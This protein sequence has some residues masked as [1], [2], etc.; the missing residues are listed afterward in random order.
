MKVVPLKAQDEELQEALKLDKLDA[1][2]RASLRVMRPSTPKHMVED[3]IKPGMAKLKSK[4]KHIQEKTQSLPPDQRD[5]QIVR[6]VAL[7]FFDGE[8]LFKYKKREEYKSGKQTGEFSP[9]DK[10]EH[11]AIKFFPGHRDG[12]FPLKLG[13]TSITCG[14]EICM[15]HNVGELRYTES[16]K[17]LHL[18]FIVSDHVTNKPEHSA[19][20]EGGYVVHA[21]TDVDMVGVFDH[22]F[23]SA[24]TRLSVKLEHG[25]LTY[26]Q[27]VLKLPS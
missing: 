15:D 2:M 8:L 3:Y 16:A 1:R 11:S 5:I 10:K 20:K 17:N 12:V 13:G 4:V 19:V 23:N 18:H 24:G 25:S 26:H 21:S 22:S 6:N 9:G 14:I 7:V 27:Q